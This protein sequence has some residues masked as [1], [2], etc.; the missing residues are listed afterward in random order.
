ME[1]DW[2]VTGSYCTYDPPWSTYE[3]EIMWSW[4]G[5]SSYCTYDPPWSTYEPGIMWSWSGGSSYCTYDPPWST[6]EP[7][8]MW[9]CLVE[10]HIVLT[11][12]LGALMSLGLC[13][14]GLVEVHIVL[15]ILLG[16]LMSLGLCGA[17]PLAWWKFIFFLMN[18]LL[19]TFFFL[20]NCRWDENCFA[21]IEGSSA[22]A[23]T[24]TTTTIGTRNHYFLVV[25]ESQPHP[26]LVAVLHPLS[27]RKY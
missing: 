1:F 25:R 13:G 16:A 23:L 8:I 18:L 10:V 9:S 5:G 6:Y 4:S 14:V 15:T 26:A 2:S 17:I 21:S 12:L 24:P 19:R 22:D 3:P 20:P 7:G 11:I 27:L